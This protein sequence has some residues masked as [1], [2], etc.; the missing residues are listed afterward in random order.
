M[1][2]GPQS[3]ALFV[4]IAFH[5]NID[6]NIFEVRGSALATWFSQALAEHN[7]NER[8]K[9]LKGEQTI[10]KLNEAVTQL[11]AFKQDSTNWEP[12]YSLH[13]GLLQLQDLAASFEAAVAEVWS[14]YECVEKEAK[15]SSCHKESL[16]K[17]WRS[18][19]TKV[20]DFFIE[21]GPVVPVIAKTV[22]DLLYDEYSPASE[23]GIILGYKCIIMDPSFDGTVPVFIDSKPD[24]FYA[25]EL[26]KVME[27]NSNAIAQK[28]KECEGEVKKGRSQGF[29]WG[30][31]VPKTPMTFAVPVDT[32][33]PLN[34]ILGLRV[35]IKVQKTTHTSMVSDCWPFPGQSVLGTVLEGRAVVVFV[36]E[37]DF[38]A[39]GHALDEWLRQRA[40][41]DLGE[42]HAFIVNKGQSFFCPFGMVPVTFG[43]PPKFSIESEVSR[44]PGQ[45][46]PK[47][48]E[49]SILVAGIVK[50][51]FHP[52]FDSGAHNAYPHAVKKRVASLFVDAGAAVPKSYRSHEGIK[53]YLEQL[54]NGA[55]DAEAV[56]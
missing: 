2:G 13:E 17:S 16:K 29:C 28:L 50:F 40:T 55:G 25:D 51:A 43:V 41:Q 20:Q 34:P 14:V 9:R 56:D 11:M 49:P 12:G 32:I 48:Q 22:A 27:D 1:N 30:T 5:S 6:S 8:V 21:H 7:G 47:A 23:H 45:S 15:L 31:M 39:H 33:K 53:A 19:R 10:R 37:S 44:R 3:D 18:P 24:C 38:V 46:R 54:G 35:G 42:A 52:I 26:Q 4:R 36:E